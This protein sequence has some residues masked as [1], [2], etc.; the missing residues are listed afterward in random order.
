MCWV[1]LEGA[2]FWGREQGLGPASPGVLENKTC[3]P[4]MGN[5]CIQRWADRSLGGR[6]KGS[7]LS[8]CP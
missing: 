6:T 7:G 3:G 2:V 1:G 5:V 4:E 8:E